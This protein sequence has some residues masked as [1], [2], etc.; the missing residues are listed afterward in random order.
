M[1]HQGAKSWS[2]T[3]AYIQIVCLLKWGIYQEIKPIIK[4]V[5]WRVRLSR[6]YFANYVRYKDTNV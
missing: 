4:L 6:Q 1:I 3:T 2:C 5:K